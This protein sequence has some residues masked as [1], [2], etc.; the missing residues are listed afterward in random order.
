MHANSKLHPKS[1]SLPLLIALLA[2]A[3][4]LHAQTCPQWVR[5]VTGWQINYNLTEAGTISGLGWVQ[6]LDNNVSVSAQVYGSGLYW[7]NSGFDAS[8][9]YIAFPTYVQANLNAILIDVAPAPD[10]PYY[11]DTT[12]GPVSVPNV[13]VSLLIRETSEN[14]CNYYVAVN[15]PPS[16][17]QGLWIPTITTTYQYPYPPFSQPSG[18][19]LWF[20]GSYDAAG[21]IMTIQTTPTTLSG[22]ITTTNFPVLGVTVTETWEISPLGLADDKVE[23][24]N[25]VPNTEFGLLVRSPDWPKYE[26]FSS[27]ASSVDMGTNL[28]VPDD[29]IAFSSLK[30]PTLVENTPWTTATD[31]I[32]VQMRD[33]VSLDIAVHIAWAGPVVGST[34]FDDIQNRVLDWV[35][36]MNDVYVAEGMGIRFDP[37]ITDARAWGETFFDES[38]ESYQKLLND[39]SYTPGKL[40]VYVVG[41][42]PIDQHRNHDEGIEGSEECPNLYY[43]TADPSAPQGDVSPDSII[44]ISQSAQESVLAHEVGHAL[45]LKHPRD[46]DPIAQLDEKNIMWTP[47]TLGLSP[48]YFSEGQTFRANYNSKSAL[49]TLYSIN[50]GAASRDCEE[51]PAS[52]PEVDKRIFADGDLLPN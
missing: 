4:V 25:P 11:V 33:L 37:V 50:P 6:F 45:S 39:A 35:A 29:V 17:S 42:L 19:D 47:L 43:N 1:W 14:P 28:T 2:S 40:N 3:G 36:F 44:V 15:N 9:T 32:K 31:N 34:T 27:A 8:G 38:C 41:D 16:S 51:S 26:S 52:C 13:S 21:T 49:R 10:S 30:A 48:R 22:S 24:T 20:V 5:S 46:Y 23:V 12:G 18:Q 7:L